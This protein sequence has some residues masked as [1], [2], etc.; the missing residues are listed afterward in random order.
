MNHAT[1]AF[2]GAFPIRPVLC[3]VEAPAPLHPAEQPMLDWNDLGDGRWACYAPAA[4]ADAVLS[5]LPA[6]QTVRLLE[7]D[8]AFHLLT[9][10]ITDDRAMQVAA[11]DLLAGF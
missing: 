4:P 1:H 10:P 3:L 11:E 7:V 2:D 5:P 6:G 8:G 9:G